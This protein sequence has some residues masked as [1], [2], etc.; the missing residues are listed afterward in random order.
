MN[1]FTLL[2]ARARSS[3]GDERGGDL[4]RL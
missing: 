4:G 2:R 1:R 3:R